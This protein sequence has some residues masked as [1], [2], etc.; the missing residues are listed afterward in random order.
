MD[1][2]A[3]REAILADVLKVFCEK[4]DVNA[5]RDAGKKIAE[6]HLAGEARHEQMLESVK[7]ARDVSHLHLRT[8]VARCDVHVTRP[9]LSRQVANSKQE[10]AE[11]KASILNPTQR[12]RLLEEHTQ[13]HDNIKRLRQVACRRGSLQGQAD[14]KIDGFFFA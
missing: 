6:L 13:V 12:Q 3:E 2:H 9:Q 5:V 4:G 7:G 10:H 14:F 1:Y 11:Q 8:P